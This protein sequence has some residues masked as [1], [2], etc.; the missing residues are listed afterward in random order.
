MFCVFVCNDFTTTFAAAYGYALVMGFCDIEVEEYIWG[1]SRV[2]ICQLCT[3]RIAVY[4]L[5]MITRL[6]TNM[7]G[8]RPH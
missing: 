7:A 6:F 3:V 5:A 2:G 1:G 4:T 8:G